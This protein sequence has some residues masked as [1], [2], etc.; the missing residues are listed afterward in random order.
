M[1]AP[2][3][4]STTLILGAWVDES[5]GAIDA[6]YAKRFRALGLTEAALMTN[7]MNATRSAPGWKLR[8]K[9]ETFA[10]AS[11]AL[12]AAG[13]SVI[14]TCWPRPDREQLAE[15]ERDMTVLAYSCGADAIEVDAEA[16]WDRKFLRGFG[17]MGEASAE[18]VAVLRRVARGRRVELDTYP[19]HTENSERALVAPHVDLLL[20]QAYSVNERAGKPVAWDSELGP[21]RMQ[22]VTMERARQTGAPATAL[23]GIGLA[24]YEQR[25][26]GHTPEEA[27]GLALRTARDLGVTRARYWSSRWIFGSTW[28]RRAIAAA[29]ASSASQST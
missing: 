1:N 7:S 9:P 4:C 28:A 25:W 3:Q 17:S 14:L 11:A 13:V 22:R 16:N 20:P 27:M 2:N 19:F 18:L 24:A 5:I 8:A 26:A 23:T 21:G 15:L 6:A 10:A 12:R 29:A